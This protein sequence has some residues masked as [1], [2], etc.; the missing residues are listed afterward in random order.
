MAQTDTNRHLMEERGQ[1]GLRDNEDEEEAYS[2]VIRKKQFKTNKGKN[3][4]LFFVRDS[5][6]EK[7][8]LER[9]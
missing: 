2:G 6:M 1:I 8:I 9:K 7:T 5:K 3:N 4:K